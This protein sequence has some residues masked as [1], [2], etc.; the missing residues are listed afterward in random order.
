M[1]RSWWRLHE[2]LRSGSKQKLS[3]PVQPDLFC[4]CGLFNNVT[5]LP[6]LLPTDSYSNSYDLWCDVP[7][8]QTYSAFGN[9][10]KLE[11]H[12][13]FSLSGRRSPT[14]S[15]TTFLFYIKTS[16]H[17][18]RDV[19]SCVSIFLSSF[20]LSHSS[21]C[22]PSDVYALCKPNILWGPGV[23]ECKG[24]A[25]AG[26]ER[27]HYPHQRAGV[28]SHNQCFPIT[29]SSLPLPLS[30]SRSL[31]RSI[32]FIGMNGSM[33]L[34]LAKKEELNNKRW[35]WTERLVSA[36]KSK[37]PPDMYSWRHERLYDLWW[38]ESLW[39]EQRRKSGDVI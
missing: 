15:P 25:E 35:K 29:H 14:F 22:S 17:V 4:L 21:I 26:R 39:R 20:F 16:T 12:F 13:C 38:P 33:I 1:G 27:L 34:I 32:C 7:R 10:L 5:L 19:A 30:P 3:R 31:I 24:S 36:L 2:Q 37:Q 11:M 8:V 28:N 6:P 18:V 9:F 23:L